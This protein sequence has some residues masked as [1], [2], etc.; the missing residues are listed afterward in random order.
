M[1]KMLNVQIKRGNATLFQFRESVVD[2][3][4][5]ITDRASNTVQV[6]IPIMSVKVKLLTSAPLG[7][8]DSLKQN[9]KIIIYSDEQIVDGAPVSPI[10]VYLQTATHYITKGQLE[11]VCVREELTDKVPFKGLL[12]VAPGLADMMLENVSIEGN[13]RIDSK[14]SI[15]MYAEYKSDYAIG[16]AWARPWDTSVKRFRPDSIALLPYLGQLTD[17]ESKSVELFYT[18]TPDDVDEYAPVYYIDASCI[19]SMDIES[20]QPPVTDV[21]VAKTAQTGIQVTF[22]AEGRMTYTPRPAWQGGG[23]YSPHYP[24]MSFCPEDGIS[25]L[26]N[27]NKFMFSDGSVV[28]MPEVP[29]YWANP[30]VKY[31]EAHE[32]GYTSEQFDA[33]LGVVVGGTGPSG[34]EYSISGVT[35]KYVIFVGSS[36]IVIC[37]RIT[38]AVVAQL[39]K[40]TNFYNYSGCLKTNDAG[41][42]EAYIMFNSPSDGYPLAIALIHNKATDSWTVQSIS[43]PAAMSYKTYT[44]SLWSSSDQTFVVTGIFQRWNQGYNNWIECI[45]C[46]LT[47]SGTVV[48]HRRYYYFNDSSLASDISFINLL[49]IQMDYA[50]GYPAK[51]RLL[52]DANLTSGS[53]GHVCRVYDV[54]IASSGASLTYTYIWGTQ[55]I[56][57][58][59]AT[60]WSGK[61]LGIY[62]FSNATQLPSIFLPIT[63][64][65]ILNLAPYVVYVKDTNDTGVRHTVPDE[66][67]DG[68]TSVSVDRMMLSLYKGWSAVLGIAM[69]YDSDPFALE[70]PS[71]D[72][73]SVRIS[74]GEENRLRVPGLVNDIKVNKGALDNDKGRVTITIQK[75]GYSPGGMAGDSTP[76]TEVMVDKLPVLA[77]GAYVKVYPSGSYGDSDV[78]IMKVTGYSLAYDGVTVATVTGII[79]SKTLSP[80]VIIYEYYG[81]DLPD[82]TWN[83]GCVMFAWCWGGAYGT[84]EWVK[85]TRESLTSLYWEV[86]EQQITGFKLCRCHA[87]TTVPYWN[88]QG[89]VPGRIYNVSADITCNNNQFTYR[90]LTLYDYYPS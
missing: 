67:P 49:D 87:G 4:L 20:A 74:E 82:W 56:S 69:F 46:K 62:P 55:Y 58:A 2:F 51:L 89:N 7:T 90:G 57:G 59:T 11:L 60:T 14:Y 28:V 45:A 6:D 65:M 43:A 66:L 29:S 27:N 21:E 54:G 18:G 61:F 77:T 63:S 8:Y 72:A 31:A 38:M 68:Y 30:D 81:Y 36:I 52:V 75:V 24:D 44:H 71:A 16:I 78:F 79:V 32:W 22:S 76:R 80:S 40:P 10:V 70:L 26:V 64:G 9:D 83:D 53:G 41:D 73:F 17:D 13:K 3:S 33:M 85:C 23:T 34:Y 42:F 19:I 5:D 35:A 39:N 47:T 86:R 50:S 48:T 84:G 1:A 25:V 88:Y 37:D 12:Y 15:D